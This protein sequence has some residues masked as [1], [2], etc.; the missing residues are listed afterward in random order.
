MDTKIVLQ[1]ADYAIIV[2]ISTDAINCSFIPISAYTSVIFTYILIL[3]IS[4]VSI[5]IIF[6]IFAYLLCVTY[7]IEHFEPCHSYHQS[8]PSAIL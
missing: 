8:V 1:L 4:N 2:L 7:R 3:L 5:I 6:V